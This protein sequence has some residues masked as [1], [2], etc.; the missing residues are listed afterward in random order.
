MSDGKLS[1]QDVKLTLEVATLRIHVE[2]A[3]E[4]VKNF[5][6]LDNSIPAPT[7]NKMFYVCAMLTNMQGYLRI[8]ELLK[9]RTNLNLLQH[10]FH[11]PQY[12]RWDRV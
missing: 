11:I 10:N 5:R 4:K 12:L 7:V 1:K 3:I 2:R 8:A 9:G 6:V